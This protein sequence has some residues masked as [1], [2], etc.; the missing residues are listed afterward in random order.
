[1]PPKWPTRVWLPDE[2]AS[3]DELPMLAC[4]DAPAE[5]N[6]AAMSSP[7]AVPTRI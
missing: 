3:S 2:Q 4:A 6:A 7:A 5:I 1:M